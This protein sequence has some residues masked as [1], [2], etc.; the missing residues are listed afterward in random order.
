MS[1]PVSTEDVP[2]QR[3]TCVNC[4]ECL[5]SGTVWR[6]FSGRYLGSGR[7]DDLDESHTCEECNGSGVTELCDLCQDMRDVDYG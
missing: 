7:C 5:G 4:G 3:C 1:D 6:S 2:A